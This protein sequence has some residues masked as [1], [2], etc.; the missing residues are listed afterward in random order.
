MTSIGAH[1]SAP[2]TLLVTGGAGFIGSHTCVELL[3][4][5]YELIV[6]DDFSN[7]TPRVFTRVERLTGRRIKAVHDV[8][9]RDRRALSAVFDRHSVDAVVH[10]AARKAV[11]E[12]T[13]LPVEYYDT[14]VGGTT[15]LLR[16][17]QQHGVHRLVFSSSCSIYGDAGRVPLDETAPARPANPYAA[18]KWA[19]EQI[20]ADV[21]RRHPEFTVLSLRY[22]NPVGAHPSGLLGEDPRGTPD[23][24]MPYVAQVAIGRRERLSVF[25]DDYDTPDGTAIRD[26]LHVM[27]TAEAHRVALEH[28]ADAPGMQV[29]NLGVG[30]GR[31][32]LDVIAAFGDACGRPIPYKIV[33]RRPGDVT[34]LVAD[35]TA[36][37][38]AWG[39]RATRDLA[40]MCRDAWRFQQHNPHGYAAPAQQRA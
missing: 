3:G 27:D 38:R 2:S 16:A 24:L 11:G 1:G 8:D 15:N 30:A 17:M 18:S 36:V 13:R 37:E 28:L 22:F 19:C 10:F 14:N 33:P 32:V 31:S 7:S 29:F 26:Y 23:N 39:W 6:V 12:S 35:A 9:V 40:A 21:C 34:E 25:G 5:G 4:H 20:L